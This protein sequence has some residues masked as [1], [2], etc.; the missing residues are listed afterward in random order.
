MAERAFR[1]IKK[2]RKRGATTIVSK[3]KI[4]NLAVNKK[5]IKDAM[6]KINKRF[7]KKFKVLSVVC[8]LYFKAIVFSWSVKDVGFGEIAYYLDEK[9]NLKLD[10]ENLSPDLLKAIQTEIIKQFKKN[11]LQI[12]MKPEALESFFQLTNNLFKK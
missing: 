4:G 10:D 9:G 12:N 6:P 7:P 3:L 5:N 11:T 2:C 1:T 8:S